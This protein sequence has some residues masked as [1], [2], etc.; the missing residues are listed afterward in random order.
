MDKT[1]TAVKAALIEGASAVATKVLRNTKEGP[2]EEFS[3]GAVEDSVDDLVD[4]LAAISNNDV[5]NLE[6][7]QALYA[8]YCRIIQSAADTISLL[9]AE[10]LGRKLSNVEFSGKPEHC[11]ALGSLRRKSR[12]LDGVAQ[13]LQ[14]SVDVEDFEEILSQIGLLVSNN[15]Y[16]FYAN[17]GDKA[18]PPLHRVGRAILKVSP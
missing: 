13:Y 6:D 10:T 14:V 18:A 2:S 11:P 1:L 7:V 15:A 5:Q 16:N 8:E 9:G 4:G 12:S 17:M 3:W